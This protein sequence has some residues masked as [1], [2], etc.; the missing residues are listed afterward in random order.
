MRYRVELIKTEEG[1]S[2]GC[3]GSSRLLVAGRAEEEAL[4]NIRDAIKDYVE[5][6]EEMR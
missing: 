6:V 1:Y 3:P 5:V 2:V 4:R